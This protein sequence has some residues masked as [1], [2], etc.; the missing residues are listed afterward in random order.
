LTRECS[1]ESLMAWLKDKGSAVRPK[2][3]YCALATILV[4][5]ATY[6][7]NQAQTATENGGSSS[8]GASSGGASNGGSAV[9]GS[10]S[11]GAS[12][13]GASSGGSAAGGQATSSG[14]NPA[15]GGSGASAGTIGSGGGP[16]A[17]AGG[18]GGTAPIT[19]G[20]GGLGNAGSAGSSA[21]GGSAGKAGGG[22]SAGNAGSGG[23]VDQLLSQGK[24]ASADSEETSKGNLA[25]LGNDGS[26]TTR[27]C[28]ADGAVGHYWQVDLGKTY[29]LSKLQLDWEKAVVYQFK[30]EGSPD[31]SAWSLILD[32]T[33]STNSVANQ[34]YPLPAAPTARWVRVTTTTLP[35]TSTW[36]S[37][38]EFQV[39]GH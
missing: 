31:G 3:A 2:V 27:W 30:V 6:Q 1:E 23:A 11:G 16:S 34:T 26:L 37:F 10:S 7:D 39:Y 19:G 35:N 38:F 9:G 33:K 20:G 22:G 25:A 24:P 21:L 13:G 29:T 14:G 18:S 15:T 8:A 32:Q 36:A 12:N 28:A 17:G 5:C 4:A